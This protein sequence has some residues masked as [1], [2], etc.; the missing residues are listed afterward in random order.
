MTSHPKTKQ[1][2]ALLSA[3]RALR[4]AADDAER[5]R[6]LDMCRRLEKLYGL[7]SE[8][9]EPPLMDAATE[10]AARFAASTHRGHV[11]VRQSPAKGWTQ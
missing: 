8:P 3:R 1:P 11:Q 10:R 9:E 2:A 7:S 5:V 4:A 6:R